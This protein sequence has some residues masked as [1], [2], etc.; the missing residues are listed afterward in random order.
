ME[1]DHRSAPA[2][3]R[4]VKVLGAIALILLAMLVV[5]HLT[6][7]GFGGHSMHGGGH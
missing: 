4:W 1:A 6:G 2:I 5:L 7:H 3:P